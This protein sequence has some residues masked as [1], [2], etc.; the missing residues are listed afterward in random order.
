MKRI[1]V[2]TGSPRT[3]GN[4]ERLADAFIKGARS[5]G[6]HVDKIAL[7]KK[8]ISGCTACNYCWNNKSNCMINDDMRE[9]EPLLE[10]ADVLVLATP[11]YWSG[12]PA[13]VKAPIDRIYEYDPANGGKRLAIKESVLLACGESEKADDFKLI[14]D[15]FTMISEFN[16]MKV[17]DVIVVPGVNFKGDIE[18]NEALIRAERLGEQI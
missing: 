18:G 13:Q 12:F 7:A 14:K 10:Q 15:A 9:I 8:A 17:R 3:N 4:S 1:L 6:H 5:A 16:G 2:W 11:L